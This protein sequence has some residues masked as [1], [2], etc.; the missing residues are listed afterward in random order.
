MVKGGLFTKLWGVILTWLACTLVNAVSA[1][2]ITVFVFGGATGATGTS[3][4]TAGFMVALED[5]LLSVLSASMIENLIDKGIAIGVAY[6]IVKKIPVRFLSQYA[7]AGRAAE[8]IQD[9][10]DDELVAGAQG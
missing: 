10:D 8:P 1:A 3:F 4:L 6:L 2:M 7:S 5:I 9:D